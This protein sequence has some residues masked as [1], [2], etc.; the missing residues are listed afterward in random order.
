MQHILGQPAALNVIQQT[1]DSR[2]VHH[3]WIFYGPAGV[4]KFT[5]AI[6]FAKVLLCPDAQADFSGHVSACGVCE[7]CR[8]FDDPHAAHP[9]LHVITKELALYSDIKA[10]RDGKQIRI[11]LDVLRTRLLEPA[12][13]KAQLNHGKVFIVDEAELLD[14]NG[15]NTLLKTLEE[16]P[17][18]SYIVLVTSQDDKLLAT[19]RSRCQR[20]A[21][22]ELS[23]EVMERWLGKQA[24][25]DAARRPW[26]LRFARGSI[27]RASLAVEYGLDGWLRA[28]EPMIE[29]MASGRAN[30]N[31]DMG[32]VMSD[33]A[34]RFAEQW[35]TN[36]ENASKDAANKQAARLLL[37]LIA[38]ICRR[39]IVTLADPRQVQKTEHAGAC[40]PWLSGIDLVRLAE[41]Q[42]GANVQSA[43]LLDNLAVQWGQAFVTMTNAV[44]E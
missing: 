14:D 35:V 3:A 39:K 42:L 37:G 30:P 12:G 11:P 20:V 25:V 22:G 9:D 28:I 27:G 38:D 24:E 33:L 21:F 41:E 5:T 43:W 40:E 8:T 2:R 4:G 13:R 19:I 23:D 6:A 1:L 34:G 16:P 36:H 10:V 15:Q 29:A 26:V 17:E 31:D 44:S 32:A 18:G 7:S